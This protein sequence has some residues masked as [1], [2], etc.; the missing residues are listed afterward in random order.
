MDNSNSSFWSTLICIG[1]CV[2]VIIGIITG[3]TIMIIAP[4]VVFG[5]I[6]LL[7]FRK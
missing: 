1:I 3:N 4:L 7:N 5:V 2:T 6:I